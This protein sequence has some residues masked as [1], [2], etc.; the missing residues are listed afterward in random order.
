MTASYSGDFSVVHFNE[1]NLSYGL[2]WFDGSS[3]VY[4]LANLTLVMSQ[5]NKAQDKHGT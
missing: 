1:I 2:A 5:F 3:I 4:M